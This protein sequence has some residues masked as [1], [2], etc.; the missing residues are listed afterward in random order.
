MEQLVSMEAPAAIRKPMLVLAVVVLE[1]LVPQVTHQPL[2]AETAALAVNG[3]WM[4]NI[5]QAVVVVPSM[6]KEVIPQ[7][8]VLVV[9][10]AAVMD[11]L[12]KTVSASLNQQPQERQT[13]VV[14]AARLPQ[15]EALASLRF[16]CRWL[17]TPTISLA[18]S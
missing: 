9:S 11:A 16:G 10:A 1:D 6:K 2:W 17:T 12:K 13:Q 15:T 8:E 5:M 3:R 4:P 18:L 14:A 7:P